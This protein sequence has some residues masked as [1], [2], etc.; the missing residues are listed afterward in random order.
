M[1]DTMRETTR[2]QDE[3]AEALSGTN[4]SVR[5]DRPDEHGDVLVT[6]LDEA[7]EPVSR[8]R[9]D[10]EGTIH[11]PRAGDLERLAASVEGLLS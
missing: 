9:V 4:A 3:V 1:P 7:G 8:L 2:E 11:P 10:L 6:C 5:V